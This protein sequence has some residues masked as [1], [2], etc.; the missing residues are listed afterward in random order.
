MATFISKDGVWYPAKERVG[1]TNITDKVKV[2]D[3]KNVEPGDPFIYDGPDRA[4]LFALWNDK[5]ETLGMNFRQDPDF[6]N[7]VRQMGF[8][9]VE[10]YLTMIGYD[11]EKVESEFKKKASVVNRHELPKR[12]EEIQKM[13]GGQDFSGM[14]ND[15]YGGFGIAPGTD[16]KSVT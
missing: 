8:K 12:V 11:K 9:D 6:I 10:E 1:L 3:G 4:A 14:G 5:V 16:G 7:R 13:G 15:I 2:I